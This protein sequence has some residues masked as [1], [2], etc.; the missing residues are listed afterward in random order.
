MRRSRT[1]RRS[2]SRGRTMRRSRGRTM[3]G[4][5]QTL[6]P[7]PKIGPPTGPNRHWG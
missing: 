2:R 1:M 6:I 3:R 5:Q 4:G 7:P